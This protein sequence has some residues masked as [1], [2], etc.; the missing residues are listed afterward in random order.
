[1]QPEDL[2]ISKPCI[3]AVVLKRDGAVL[4]GLFREQLVNL[5]RDGPPLLDA[6]QSGWCV[7]RR[8]HY[9]I[10]ELKQLAANFNLELCLGNR[11]VPRLPVQAGRIEN[12]DNDRQQLL[13][14]FAQRA[15][16]RRDMRTICR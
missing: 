11:E 7:Q 10:R 9:L 6:L 1:M 15:S 2:D 3:I 8:I 16:R 5:R 4:L 14:L 12:I 13:M